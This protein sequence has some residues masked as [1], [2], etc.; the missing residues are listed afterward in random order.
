MTPRE[1]KLFVAA[2]PW[3]LAAA[4]KRLGYP[5][6]RFAEADVPDDL[7]YVIDLDALAW[8][9]SAQASAEHSPPKNPAVS[10]VAEEGKP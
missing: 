9:T 8:P 1:G 7:V 10:V 5:T 3:L 4:A 6:E 2:N